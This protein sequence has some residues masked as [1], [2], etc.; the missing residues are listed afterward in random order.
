MKISDMQLGPMAKL[1]A[2]TLL[3]EF[4]SDVIKFLR[5]YRDLRM[6]ASDMAGNIRRNKEWLIQTYT[7]RDRPSSMIA[8]KLQEVVYKN[9]E[10]DDREQITDYLH[11][12]LLAIP[13][14][15][16]LSFHCNT[17]LGQ[18]ASEAFDIGHLEDSTGIVTPVGFKVITRIRLLL[19]LETFL[20]REG[21]LRIWHLQFKQRPLEV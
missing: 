21:G 2:E 13:N 18:P 6:Q 17:L 7:R 16:E 1:G 5:G 10:I 11:T 19:N 12:A 4:G 9:I 20:R 15:Y 8:R 14:A 3:D